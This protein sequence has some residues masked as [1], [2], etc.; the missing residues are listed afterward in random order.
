VMASDLQD[1]PEMIPTF[2]SS[3]VFQREIADQIRVDLGCT[4]PLILLYDV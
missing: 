2:V 4:N 1:P 3:R